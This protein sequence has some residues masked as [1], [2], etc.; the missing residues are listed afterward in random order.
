MKAPSGNGSPLRQPRPRLSGDPKSR[1]LRQILTICCQIRAV[2]D[3]NGPKVEIKSAER[4]PALRSAATDE[5]LDRDHPCAG[6]V[7]IGAEVPI[8]VEGRVRIPSLSRAL[9]KK[10]LDRRQPR[11]PKRPRSARHTIPRRKIP[12]TAACRGVFA[13]P[14]QATRVKPCC[15]HAAPS[16]HRKRPS[17]AG[18]SRGDG[19][20]Y[21]K[22]RERKAAAADGQS[23]EEDAS[24][25]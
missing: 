14:K 15:P 3:P 21:G 17:A 22:R 24:I 16:D 7:R 11:M 8:G 1:T 25:C 23:Y 13:T 20:S 6:D 18:A 2:R 12:P 10:M 4:Q 19:R 5:M 9:A